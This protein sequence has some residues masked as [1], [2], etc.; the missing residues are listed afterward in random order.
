MAISVV[1]GDKE[2]LL[3]EALH[4]LA[5]DRARIHGGGIADTEYVPFAIGAGDRVGVTAGHDVED[6][7]FAGHLRHRI[8]DTGIDVAK[9]DVALVA[10]DQLAR[11]LYTGPDVI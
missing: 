2:P 1:R 7:L 5:G 11:L 3:A 10:I 4:Q 8:G 6:L 9:D